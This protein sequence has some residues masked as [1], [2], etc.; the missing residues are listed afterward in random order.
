MGWYWILFGVRDANGAGWELAQRL[1]EAVGLDAIPNLIG[2]AGADRTLSKEPYVEL[3]NSGHNI[4]H[5]RLLAAARIDAGWAK[6]GAPVSASWRPTGAVDTPWSLRFRFRIISLEADLSRAAEI[7]HELAD[8]QLHPSTGNLEGRK[9][10]T[11]SVDGRGAAR[12]A[13]A[14]AAALSL[15]AALKDHLTPRTG[16]VRFSRLKVPVPRP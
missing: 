11:I 7:L 8:L 6:L 15:R 9:L 13:D 4:H 14:A 3:F 16:S 5:A 1:G 2:T 12:G 10:V